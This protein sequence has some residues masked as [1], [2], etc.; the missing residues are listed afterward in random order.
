[1]TPQKAAQLSAVELAKVKAM[2]GALPLTLALALALA[3]A[4]ALALALAL[5]GT[6]PRC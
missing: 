2:P 5:A 1:M 4:L 3:P 6:C